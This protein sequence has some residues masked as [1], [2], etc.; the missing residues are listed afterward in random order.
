MRA[1]GVG[2]P[3]E[4]V[5]KRRTGP[6]WSRSSHEHIRVQGPPAGPEKPAMQPHEDTSTA[7]A[8]SVVVLVGQVVHELLPVAPP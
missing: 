1:G 6:D 8:L 4:P 7:P 2:P 3:I 5:S